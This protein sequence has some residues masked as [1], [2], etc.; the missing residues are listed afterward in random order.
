MDGED[1][2]GGGVYPVFRHPII[3]Y[4]DRTGHD[5][6]EK[7][8]TEP[9]MVTSAIINQA[10]REKHSNWFIIGLVPN[11]HMIS[12]A[13]RRLGKGRRANRSDSVRDYH[14]CL[15]TIL[16]SLVDC[17]RE[18]P[19]FKIR[20]GDRAIYARLKVE[21]ALVV[22]DN[23]SQN[24]LSIRVDDYSPSTPR[25]GRRCLTEYC[26]SSCPNHVCHPINHSFVE[27]LCMAALGCT[28]GLQDGGQQPTAPLSE[29]LDRYM[30]FVD[31]LGTA[32]ERLRIK[33]AR[34]LRQRICDDVLR[35]VFGSHAVDCAFFQVDFGDQPGK[36]MRATVT[37]ILHTVEEGL[38]KKLFLP[39]VGSLPDVTRTWLDQLVGMMFDG[40]NRSGERDEYPRVN[41]TRGYTQLTNLSA[42]ESVGQLFVLAVILQTEMG[43]EIMNSRFDL[44]YDKKRMNPFEQYVDDGGDDDDG[45]GD[46]GGDV[47]GGEGDD[48]VGDY[49]VGVVS[50]VEIDLILEKLRLDFLVN[51]ILPRIP[52]FHQERM[53]QVF[54][55]IVTPSIVKRYN[56]IPVLFPLDV[57]LDY[58]SVG[59]EFQHH[60]TEQ[61]QQQQYNY[62]VDESVDGFPFV[63]PD[64]RID[65]SLKLWDIS[66]LSLLV[67]SV[68]CFH[69]FLKHGHHLLGHEANIGAYKR[70]LS[71][72][73]HAVVQFIQKKPGVPLGNDMKFLELSHFLDDQLE[74][75]CAAG[76]STGTGERCLKKWVKCPGKTVQKR[77]DDI[78]TSQTARQ[79]YE[80]GL[81]N[82]IVESNRYCLGRVGK[83]VVG[84]DVGVVTEGDDVNHREEENQQHQD[85]CQQERIRMRNKNFICHVTKDKA[86]IHRMVSRTKLHPDQ[87]EFPLVVL[88]WF[89]QMFSGDLHH[90][91]NNNNNNNTIIINN[92]DNNN[93][94]THDNNDNEDN[95]GLE[96]QNVNAR[97]ELFIQL[98]TEALISDPESGVSSS[99]IRSHP[100]FAGGTSWYD[101]VSVKYQYD[102]NGQSETFP[103]KVFVMY[104][105]PETRQYCFLGQE[106]RNQTQ[107]MKQRETLL[108]DHW[109]LES[110]R[111]PLTDLYQPVLT[112]F[113]MEV[114]DAR[115]YVIDLDPT[116]G[117]SRPCSSD[118]G[119]LQVKDLKAEWSKQ[120]LQSWEMWMQYQ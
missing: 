61:Q 115:I 99:L 45:G 19:V 33:R 54:R 84:N 64:N 71:F 113:Q 72:L 23:K 4:M 80:H 58:R 104:Q 78:F 88:N 107:T 74:F 26:R 34:I 86:V 117:L 49:E 31:G 82:S 97:T 108:F 22:G 75:G 9:V 39:L 28:Y 43:R 93:N 66:Q 48:C 70:S 114:I 110:A 5:M 98:F 11:L 24:C 41:F 7:N 12:S 51:D 96:T 18:M 112:S 91:N 21:V 92:N 67:E 32:N 119:I 46:D 65:C 8:S 10:E 116:K 77:S 56:N 68:L 13:Q 17:Q 106:V 50:D 47:H 53:R 20:R 109:C 52:V 55:M 36:I 62:V 89:H 118:F 102:H 30:Q 95:G 1:V 60:Q 73:R 3:L 101:F 37:D 15:K 105:H 111:D 14:R 35:R 90:G 120:F 6:K 94:N 38:M 59:L 63:C 16:Q 2:G 69:S 40:V 85:H 42:D 76:F 44:E 29:N 83:H 100:Q 81:I 79:I 25:M 57:C 27:K 103:V 87:V